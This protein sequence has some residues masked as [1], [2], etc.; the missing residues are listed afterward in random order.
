MNPNQ[1]GAGTPDKAMV[2][3]QVTV[4]ENIAQAIE[5]HNRDIARLMKL[6]DDAERLG[7]LH[8]PHRLLGEMVYPHNAF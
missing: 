5:S 2:Q 1:C 8:V 7:L 4:G 6:R 3:R